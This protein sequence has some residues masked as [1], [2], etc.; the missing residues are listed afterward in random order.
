MNMW[1]L[2]ERVCRHLERDLLDEENLNYFLRG[3]LRHAFP[4]QAPGG[5]QQWDLSTEQA[6]V[7]ED[8]FRR[9]RELEQAR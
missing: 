3:T 6:Q 9:L 1:E 8:C 5:G 7:I 4:K 2:T